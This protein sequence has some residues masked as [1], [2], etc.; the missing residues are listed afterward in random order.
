MESESVKSKAGDS[1]IVF[2]PTTPEDS[3]AEFLE[4]QFV[5]PPA[6]SDLKP[7]QFGTDEKRLLE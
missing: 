1:E 2:Q 3:N 4:S 6:D 7:S 5:E